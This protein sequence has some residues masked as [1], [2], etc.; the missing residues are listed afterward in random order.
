MRSANETQECRD[1]GNYWFN[2][3]C[4]SSVAC[5]TCGSLNT[6]YTGEIMKAKDVKRLNRKKVSCADSAKGEKK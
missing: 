5:P 4:R 6:F 2:G 3:I 1:C